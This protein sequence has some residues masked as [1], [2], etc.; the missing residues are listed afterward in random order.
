MSDVY[1]HPTAEV[2]PKAKIGAGSKI[3]NHAQVR[4]DTELGKNCVLSKNVYIDKGVKIGD[5]CKIQNNVSIYYPCIIDDDVFIGPSVTFTNDMYP[6]AFIWSTERIS[7]PTKIKKGA[8]VG[9]NATLICGI[10]LGEYCMIAA[11]SVVTKDV[12]AHA[13]IMGVPG[14]IKG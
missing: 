5:G 13:L 3:W 9:A 7:S 8:S 10:T 4:E 6:R 12:P 14:K 11:G 2:S 1:I